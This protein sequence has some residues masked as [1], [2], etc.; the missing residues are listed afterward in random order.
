M[1]AEDKLV[2]LEYN[3][4]VSELKLLESELEY[5]LAF[6][7][8]EKESFSNNYRNELASRDIIFPEPTDEPEEKLNREQRRKRKK[9]S[10]QIKKLYKKIAIETHPDKL[11]ALSPKDRKRKER[12]F[13]AAA[14]AFEEGKTSLLRDLASE[15]EIP[16]PPIVKEDIAS[17]SEDIQEKKGEVDAVKGTVAYAWT[18]ATDPDIRDEIMATYV[19]FIVE[20]HACES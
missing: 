13:R 8:S 10:E 12:L 6:V 5:Y 16:L 11:A 19:D 20:A 18:M 4:A 14:T 3:K 7:D 9:V 2:V 17:V 1:S 15:L